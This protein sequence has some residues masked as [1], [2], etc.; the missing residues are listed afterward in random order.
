MND[1]IYQQFVRTQRRAAALFASANPGLCEIQ[2]MPEPRFLVRFHCPVLFRRP[3]E[4]IR[5]GHGCDVGITLGPDYLR[6]IDP[7]VATLLTPFVFHP[8]MRGGGVCLGRIAPATPLIDILVQ[9]YEMLVW[10][11]FTPNDC[12][13]ADA[14][15]WARNHPER[16]PLET[17]R[18][19]RIPKRE[20]VTP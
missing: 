16:V 13:D 15:Q 1:P 8:N 14:A 5:V 19:I 18:A 4:A 12:L 17:G 7:G 3:G 11:A 2:P 9:L 20:E 10:Q 6:R